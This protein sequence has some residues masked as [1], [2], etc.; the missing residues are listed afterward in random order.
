MIPFRNTWPYETIREDVYI[1]EC[2][3]CQKANV[4]LPLKKKDL[5]TIHEG[6]KWLIVFP[7]CHEKVTAID[8][9]T[10]YILADLPLR[11]PAP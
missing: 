8:V 7:C 5:Q 9:D 6:R 11:R 1:H 10:D 4:L 3:F 2:P